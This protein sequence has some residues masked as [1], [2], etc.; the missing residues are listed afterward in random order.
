MKNFYQLMII[1]FLNRK[2]NY[3]K[4]FKNNDLFSYYNEYR[5][6]IML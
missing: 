1:I 6:Y 4:Q 3:L 2:Y 5:K